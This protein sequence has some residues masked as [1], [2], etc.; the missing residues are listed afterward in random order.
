MLVA[1]GN[2]SD[3]FRCNPLPYLI[4]GAAQVARARHLVIVHDVKHRID[5]SHR[6]RP[7]VRNRCMDWVAALHQYPV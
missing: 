1:A 4:P 3:N 7:T 5:N 2:M 6:E